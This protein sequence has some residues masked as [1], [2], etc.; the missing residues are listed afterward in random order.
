MSSDRRSSDKS[1]VDGVVFELEI[2][3]EWRILPPT[4]CGRGEVG[5]KL[6]REP[7]GKISLRGFPVA[8]SRRHRILRACAAFLLPL[9][10]ATRGCLTMIAI[11]SFTLRLRSMQLLKTLPKLSILLIFLPVAVY[12]RFFTDSPGL[13][14][15]IVS[16]LGI[17]GT[18]TLIGKATEEIA[19]YAGPLWGGLLN[20]TFGNVTELIIALFALY[21]GVQAIRNGGDGQ[22]M[23]DVVRASLIGSIIGNLLLIL[24]GAMLYGG[25]KFTTQKFSR[26]GA[27]VNVGML[28][29][30]VICLMVPSL[31]DMAN[32]MHAFEHHSAVQVAAETGGEVHSHHLDPEKANA[33]IGDVSMAA[34]L[35]LLGLYILSLV[36]SLRTHRFLL[37]PDGGSHHEQAVWSKGIAAS[38]LLGATLCVAFLSEI[39]VHSIEQMNTGM[40]ELFIGVI[41]VAVVGNAAEGLVAVWVARDNKMELS[42]QIAMGSCLQVA[43][44]VAPVLVLASWWMGELMPLTFHPFELLSLLAAVLIATAALND[45]ESN[46]LEGAMFLAVY[47]FFAIVFF[48]HP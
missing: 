29:V 17:L 25:L 2:V 11:D 19:V 3:R 12:L 18:V 40:S 1:S 10:E 21:A 23:F 37:M 34:A 7:T 36:F 39:F 15:F 44:M 38:F 24:G 46:W 13:A 9:L 27:Q 28:W 26:T 41:I 35:I 48:V 45:G 32:T 42:F 8:A 14:L 6:R 31:V 20:A 4:G 22:Q 33:L 43:L 47:L 16:A 5:D 30:T